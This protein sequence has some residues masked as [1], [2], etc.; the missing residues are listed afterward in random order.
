M[1][2]RAAGRGEKLLRRIVAVLVSL[3]LL[4]ERAAD[5]PWRV[6]FLVLWLLRRAEKVA[7]GFVRE[8]TGR[9]VIFEDVAPTGNSPDDA[10]C[11]AERLRG[12]AAA[13]A[14]LLPDSCGFAYRPARFARPGFSFAQTALVFVRH[15]TGWEPRP[16][17]SS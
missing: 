17:D 5:R 12:L 2:R 4:A 16:I 11:I 9:L 6:R 8:E 10:R 1:D 14:A 15:L 13:L 3:A 7:C